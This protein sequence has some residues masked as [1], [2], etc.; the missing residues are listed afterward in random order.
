MQ[1]RSTSR[2]WM[3]YAAS[4]G[5]LLLLYV[6]ERSAV[7]QLQDLRDHDRATITNLKE[8]LAAQTMKLSKE[9]NRLVNELEKQKSKHNEEIEQR[10]GDVSDRNQELAAKDKQLLECK[11]ELMMSKEAQEISAQKMSDSAAQ[12][13]IAEEQLRATIF[14]L[15]DQKK[16][17]Q[18]EA[19][20]QKQ[21]CKER[22]DQLTSALQG[23]LSK[24]DEHK[25][26]ST[27][28]TTTPQ[29]AQTHGSDSSLEDVA[30]PKPSVLP[31]PRPVAQSE[32]PKMEVKKEGSNGEASSDSSSS[33]QLDDDQQ[34]Q[35]QQQQLS[36][37]EESSVG[38]NSEMAAEE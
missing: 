4:I 8:D 32:A 37:S 1:Y 18:E 27:S 2:V 35:Q 14:S 19:V 11:D 15:E 36:G 23:C 30:T 16:V 34:Q 22:R 26:E 38:S 25:Q 7:D 10:E 13:V 33:Q 3:L 31:T 24:L 17:L 5:L 6:R 12:A 28:P 21:K 20:A 9:N 29:P